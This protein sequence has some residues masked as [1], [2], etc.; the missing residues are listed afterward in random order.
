MAT[1]DEV[2]QEWGRRFLNIRE[3]E[4]RFYDESFTDGGC[5]T[6]GYGGD[7]AYKLE[8]SFGNW[9]DNNRV[10][11]N[12]DGSMTSLMEELIELTKEIEAR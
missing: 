12:W 6:C 1:V 10:V 9:G 7:Q 5:E 2:M 3:G 4:V 8:V 11:K